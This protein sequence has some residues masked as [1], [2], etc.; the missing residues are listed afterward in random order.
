ME[1]VHR[2]LELTISPAKE[3][4]DESGNVVPVTRRV[5]AVYVV[6]VMDG[7]AV[8][9]TSAPH[10][11][12]A[13]YPPGDEAAL[14]REY[15]IEAGASAATRSLADILADAGVGSLGGD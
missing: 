8:F 7:A 15:T 4:H 13:D 1:K 11:L 14:A 3:I 5:S 9:A 10:R 2:L 12:V 6:D